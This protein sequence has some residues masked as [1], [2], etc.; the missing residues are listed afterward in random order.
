MIIA[1]MHVNSTV[2]LCQPSV[3]LDDGGS[4]HMS[5]TQRWIWDNWQ[6]MIEQV[7]RMRQ[8]R[9]ITVFNGDVCEADAKR[10]SLQTISRNPAT[11]KAHAADIIDPVAK[12]SDKVYF[13]R[14][15]PAHSGKSSH[16]EESLAKDF[17]AVKEPSTGASSW[18]HLPLEVDGVR[19]DI[20]HEAS[21]SGLPWNVK[22]SATRYAARVLFQ[23]AEQGRVPPHLAIRSHVHRWADSYDDYPVRAIFTG[24]WS[25]ATEYIN[26]LNAGALGQLGAMVILCD[27]GE[28]EVRK[29]QYRERAKQW[30]RA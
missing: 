1:D 20:A 21:M 26:R 24:C 25:A 18:Y 15:T 30:T 29:I 17:S 12:M 6:D 13:T 8:G 14:G 28:Y 7:T 9:L 4:Y 19:F 10:R 3:Q 22:T 5:K 11:I 23:Y 2:A 16:Y 27:K